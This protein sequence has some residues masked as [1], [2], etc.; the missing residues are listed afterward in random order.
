LAWARRLALGGLSAGQGI[1]QFA[2]AMGEDG[3]LSLSGLADAYWYLYTQP[4]TAWTHE[5]DLR[6]FKESF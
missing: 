3:M 2:Q 1:P 6:T 5:L 4:K